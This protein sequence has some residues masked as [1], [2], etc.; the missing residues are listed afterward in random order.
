LQRP[1]QHFSTS[2]YLVFSIVLY[3]LQL[4]K[5][6]PVGQMK[7]Q[8]SFIAFSKKINENETSTY[9]DFENWQ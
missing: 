3:H 9:F 1:T 5:G 6:L 7:K 4:K 8:I 2:Y